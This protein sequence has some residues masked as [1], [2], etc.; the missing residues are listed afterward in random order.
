VADALTSAAFSVVVHR[1]ASRLDY[2]A[3]LETFAFEFRIA[4][5]ARVLSPR[6]RVRGESSVDLDQPYADR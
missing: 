4:A 5:T 2:R 1:H 6:F 3:T